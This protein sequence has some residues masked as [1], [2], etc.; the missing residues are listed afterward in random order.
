MHTIYRPCKAPFWHQQ[1][2]AGA[3]ALKCRLPDRCAR[4]LS[5]RHAAAHQSPSPA[6]T[7]SFS[8]Q[9]FPCGTQSRNG[10]HSTHGGAAANDDHPSQPEVDAGRGWL[11]YRATES[12]VLCRSVECLQ[13]RERVQ[14]L[15]LGF[16]NPLL[17]CTQTFWFL[18]PPA[19]GF[20]CM[21]EVARM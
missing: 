21:E 6:A 3:V 20:V 4:C 18:F 8:Q 1:T 14:C 16:R 10:R 9:S 12:W 5:S 19:L 11:L 15:G 13:T 17:H 2:E 7:S